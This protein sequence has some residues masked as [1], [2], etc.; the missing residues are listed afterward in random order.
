MNLKHLCLRDICKNGAMN[1]Q[2]YCSKHLLDDDKLRVVAYQWWYFLS[3]N[4]R[5]YFV[6]YY[7]YNFRDVSHYQASLKEIVQMYVFM[8]RKLKQTFNWLYY[9]NKENKTNEKQ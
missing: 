4:D 7:R 5:R 6:E 3:K 1:G 9:K 2:F 8:T